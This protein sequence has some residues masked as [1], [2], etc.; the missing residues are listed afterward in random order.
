MVTRHGR[1]VALLSSATEPSV[2]TGPGFG[3]GA[4]KPLFTRPATRGRYLAELVSDRDDP[5]DAR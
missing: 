3:K 1:A 2:V 4:L 5:G